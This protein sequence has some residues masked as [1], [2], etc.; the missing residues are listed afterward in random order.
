MAA[1]MDSN[2]P[3]KHRAATAL[4]GVLGT[5]AEDERVAD[6]ETTGDAGEAS[7]GDDGGAPGGEDALRLV[8]VA[9][10]QRLRH[11][12]REDGIPEELESLV[13]LGRTLGV[14]V[15]IAAVDERFG[16]KRGVV[17]MQPETLGQVAG[18][19]WHR[20]RSGLTG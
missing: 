5:L 11:H 8:A 12:Q 1:T 9:L 10:E 18:A 15:H 4:A 3:A 7:R 19:R 6:L 2:R 16:Q 20:P 17:E 14:L 13:G